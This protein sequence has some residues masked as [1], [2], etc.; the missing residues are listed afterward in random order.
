MCPNWVLMKNA[1]KKSWGWGCCTCRRRASK[2]WVGPHGSVTLSYINTSP[3]DQG[4]A[5]LLIQP[6]KGSTPVSPVVHAGQMS[7]F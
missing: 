2:C 6:G 3:R 4:R 5:G 7:A 1:L